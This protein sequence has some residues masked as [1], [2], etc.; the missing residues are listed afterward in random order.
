M[1]VALDLETTGVDAKNDKILE[2]ALVKFNEKT[3][4]IVDTFSTLINPWVPIPEMISHITNIFDEDVKTSPFFGEE[5]IQKIEDFIQDLPIL[6]HNSNFDREFL[7][8]NGVDL[9]KNILLDTFH[10][11]NIILPYEKSL[12]LWSLCDSLEIPLQDAHRALDDTI[13]TVKLFEKLVSLFSKLPKK[14]QEVLTFLFSLWENPSFWYYRDLF[15]FWKN[16]L[17]QEDFIKNILATI[18]KYKEKKDEDMQKWSDT[19]TNEYIQ[20]IFT[21]LPHSEL[22][23]NQLEMSYAIKEVLFENKKIAIEAPTGVGKTF[24]YLIPSILKSLSSGEQVVISTNTKALQDQIFYKDLAF[25]EQHLP[26]D[27]SYSK[28]KGRRNYFSVSR[29]FEYIFSHH[30]LSTDETVFFSKIVLWLFDTTFWELDELNLYPQEHYFVKNIN[31][32]YF[33][34][35]FENNEYKSYEYIFKARSEAMTSNIVIVNHSLLVQDAGSTQPIFG[36]IQNLILD[37]GHNLE[38]TMTDALIKSFTLQSLKDSIEKIQNQLKKGSFFIDNLDIKFENFFWQVSLL[39]DLFLDY[40]MKQN[41]FGNDTYQALIEKDFFLQNPNIFNLIHSLEIQSIEIFNHL[42]TSPDKVFQSLKSEIVN[43]EEIIDIVK[44][45]SSESASETFIPMFSYGK[46]TQNTLYYTVLNPW[47]FLKQLLWDKIPSI[48]LTSATLK[49]ND[50]FSYIENI[51]HLKDFDFLALKSDFDYAKQA[52]LFIPNDL[53]TVK[54]NNPKVQEF[55]LDFLAIVKGKTLALF[56][57]FNSIREMYLSLH[58]PLKKLG[59]TLLSQWVSG[60]KHKIANH[61]KKNA[62]NSVILGTDSFWEWVDIPGDDLKYLIIHKF[63]FL[64]P[65]DPIF[66]ARSKL[67]QNAFYEY[68]IPKAII[69][70]RQWFGRLIRSKT[71]TGIVVLLDD[72]YF[73]TVWGVAMKSSFP[74]D[75]NI[76]I[77]NSQSFLELLKSKV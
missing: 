77:G 69:K 4:E 67:Y 38:D 72:R 54:Y 66:K 33:L 76:K 8:Q 21:H 59:T 55:V 2:I 68:S 56:T 58:F 64:V 7:L 62:S 17:E 27:F 12:N 10:L 37:E 47:N 28:L 6:W 23:E 46:N 34:V 30:T 60:S 11:A 19:I 48:A 51:L 44:V 39:F 5:Q 65:I 49:I 57:S 42:Q 52:L 50:T 63:P 1:I 40:A 3:F 31:S 35:L 18:G 74:H 61:F 71:D 53:G 25:L 15:W 24:A 32:D 73:S 16:T 26:Y 36:H 22:R 41:T 20:N 13:A 14:K 9:E 70:T 75:I 29:F 45:C 43:M